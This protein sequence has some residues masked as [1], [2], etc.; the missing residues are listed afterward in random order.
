MRK[1]ASRLVG[2][3]LASEM[4]PFAFAHKDGGEVIKAAPFAF[5]PNLWDK[6]KDLLDQNSDTER[7]Y[8]IYVITY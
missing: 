4:V 7:G 2:N 5:V 8:Y 6:V 3:N 1:E